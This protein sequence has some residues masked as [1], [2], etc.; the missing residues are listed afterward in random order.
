MVSIIPIHAIR[1]RFCTFLDAD[2]IF[3]ETPVSRQVVVAGTST[4]LLC[5]AA[6]QDT[7]TIEWTKDGEVVSL[8]ALMEAGNGVYRRNLLFANLLASDTGSYVCMVTSDFQGV[9]LTSD[10]ARLDVFS[11]FKCTA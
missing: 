9:T 5:A 2:P 11:E 10:P 1:H 7:L 8:S 3:L 6:S 4:T